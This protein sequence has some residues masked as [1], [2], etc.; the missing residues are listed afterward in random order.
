MKKSYLSKQVIAVI[1]IITVLAVSVPVYFAVLRPYFNKPSENVKEAV[2]CIE[3]EL[4]KG[5]TLRIM[6]V[7]ENSEKQVYTMGKGQESW[8]FYISD[9]AIYIKDYELTP[10][11]GNTMVA[12][13]SSLASPMC[14][15]VLP[16]EEEMLDMRQKKADRLT[17]EEIEKWGGKDKVTLN[18]EDLKDYKLPLEDYG[19][20][21]PSNLNYYVTT[22]KNGV[23]HKV[24]IGDYTPDGESVYAM[25]EGRKA[26]YLISSTISPFFT[27]SLEEVA[28][29]ILT[30]VP[31]NAESDYV[32]DSFVI[33]KGTTPYINIVHYDPEAALALDRTTTSILMKHIYDDEEGKPVYN[34]YD[35]SGDYSMLLYNNFRASLFG[36]EVVAVSPCEPI[37]EDAKKTYRQLDISEEVLE[38][39]GIFKDDPYMSFYYK[40]GELINL[41]VFSAPQTDDKGDFYYVYNAQYEFIV[42]V[43]ADKVSFM[44]KEETYFLSSYVSMIPLDNLDKLTVDS[45]SL[46]DQYLNETAGVKKLKESFKLGFKMNAAGT[47]KQLS[48]EGGPILEKVTLSGGGAVPDAGKTTGLDN[49]KNFYYHLLRIR[50]YTNVEEQLEEINKVDLSRPDVSVSYEIYKGKTHTLNFYFY[51]ASGN[52]CFYTYDE[53]KERYVVD[54]RDVGRMLKALS[55]VQDG[56][57]VTEAL[58]SIS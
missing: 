27:L 43:Y 8:S 34:M 41:L 47:D 1:V 3:G 4:L 48:P 57:S 26:I 25:Y 52:L 33:Y 32:P 15:R 38:K 24:Y 39:Y 31:S 20:E 53:G 9:G 21:D 13:R 17:A 28:S 40:K 44:E 22:D 14:K 55:L 46:K 6:K 30:T 12:L 10:Y 23:T 49:F 7:D 29:P 58:G 50:M 5:D 36:S 56:K 51:G 19:L 35:T 18:E 2:P 42:K 16:T 11:D 45:T 37:I 54:N